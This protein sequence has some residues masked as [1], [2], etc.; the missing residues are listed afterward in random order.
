LTFPSPS[1]DKLC[2]SHLDKHSLSES[3]CP[4]GTGCACPSGLSQW[5][6]PGTGTTFLK[7]SNHDADAWSIQMSNEKEPAPSAP[8]SEIG[9]DNTASDAEQAS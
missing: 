8:R 1:W 6:K 2:L 3:A 4:T 9:N 5:D 7:S